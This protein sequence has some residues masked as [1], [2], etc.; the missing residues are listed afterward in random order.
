MDLGF[1]KKFE[2]KKI[3]SFFDELAERIPENITSILKKIAIGILGILA[4]IAIYYGIG[5]GRSLAQQEGQELAK[6]TKMLFREEIEREYN[7]KRKDIRMPDT[8]RFLDNDDSHKY[9]MRYDASPVVDL[10]S[11]KPIESSMDYINN[12]K[13][14][15][16]IQNSKEV[17]LYPEDLKEIS[18][19]PVL[20]S[21]EIP[22]K[23]ETKKRIPQMDYPPIMPEE[24]AL[25]KPKTDNNIKIPIGKNTDTSLTPPLKSDKNVIERQKTKKLPLAPI[26]E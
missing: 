21:N 18:G 7:R 23:Y 8:S 26:E 3:L 12:Q 19:N 14:L 4:V 16:S 20:E 6:D 2:F 11:N 17:S 22:G 25:L 9:E 13:D 5:I 10:E 24:P 15:R 1:L